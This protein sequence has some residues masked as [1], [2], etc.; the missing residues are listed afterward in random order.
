MEATG[1][2][3]L[4]YQWQ[5]KTS[6]TAGWT[7]TGLNGNK[8]ETLSFPVKALYDGR[9]YRCKITDANGKQVTSGAANLKLVSSEIMIDLVVYEPFDET[10]C[11]V[12]EYRG[13]AA[14]LTIPE[15]VQNMTVTEIGESAFENNSTLESID[16]PDTITVIGKKAFKNCSNLKSMN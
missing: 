14:T 15:T 8:T 13:N 5:T 12:K 2:E 4:T 9:K 3:P 16:L 1:T 7:N 10:T 11:F 6:P